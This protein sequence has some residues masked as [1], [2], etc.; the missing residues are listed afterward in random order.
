MPS[1]I[2]L[3][4]FAS[5]MTVSAQAQPVPSLTTRDPTLQLQ[6][7]SPE[8]FR[9]QRRH[10]L[11]LAAGLGIATS[12]LAH[13]AVYAADSCNNDSR[14]SMAG[15]GAGLVVGVGFTI[16]GGTLMARDT[17]KLRASP[18]QK[19]AIVLTALGSAVLTQAL[20]MG[21]WAVQGA[22]ACAS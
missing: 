13:F 18:G 10:R 5:L 16:F 4:L 20:L 21:V 14:A 8:L 3:V 11:L 6:P 9:A 17:P 15:A 19:V 1:L 22:G 2:W 7:P 12:S